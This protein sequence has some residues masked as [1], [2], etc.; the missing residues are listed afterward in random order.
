MAKFHSFF[1]LCVYVCMYIFFIHLSLIAPFSFLKNC[2]TVLH[3][4]C[5]S[6]HSH[7][8]WGFPF[9]HIL[10]NI[11]YLSSFWWPPWGLSWGTRWY[12]IVALIC[13][14]LIVNDVEYLFKC[15]D[16]PCGLVVKPMS[17]TQEIRVWSLGQKDPLEEEMATHSSNHAWEIPWT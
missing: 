14:S 7:S 13:F 12:L 11:C 6:L 3:R 10:I 5:T 1:W 2:H 17:E 8:V 4:G 16:F 15:L 9:L